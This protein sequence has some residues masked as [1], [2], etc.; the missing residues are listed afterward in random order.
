MR[1]LRE[2]TGSW[3]MICISRLNARSSEVPIE[4]TSASLEPDLSR[5]R[6]DETENRAPGGRLAAPRL[7]DDAQRLAA[8]DVEGDVADGLNRAHL[9]REHAL[10]DGKGFLEV[11]YGKQRRSSVHAAATPSSTTSGAWGWLRRSGSIAR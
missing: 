9:A 10:L 3:K 6:L 8:R 5:R 1:G 7:A 2:E 11:S 4:F